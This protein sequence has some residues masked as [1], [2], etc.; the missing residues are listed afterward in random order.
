[1]KGEK[2]GCPLQRKGKKQVAQSGPLKKPSLLSCCPQL[3]CMCRLV[4]CLRANIH[5]HR[6]QIRVPP[7]QIP[8][9]SEFGEGK[10]RSATQS[11]WRW[12]FYTGPPYTSLSLLSVRPCQDLDDLIV[13]ELN[14]VFKRIHQ[15]RNQPI[16]E[17]N[18]QP[19]E[20]SINQTIHQPTK[21]ITNQ[22]ESNQSNKQ[23]TNQLSK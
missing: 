7:L 21:Q 3:V 18:N 6:C 19:T 11:Q 1:M 10:E 4:T 17:S 12:Y 20:Q 13:W 2:K 15:L 14:S 23:S 9:V 8:L 5:L 22:P 16:S